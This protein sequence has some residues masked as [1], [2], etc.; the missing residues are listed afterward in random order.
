M[1]EIDKIKTAI[2]ALSSSEIARLR[3]WLATLDAQEF[4]A[5]LERD[6]RTGM[7]DHL[8]RKALADDK[9]KKT[10]DL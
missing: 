8:A 4:D 7:L 3:R 2:K 6:A 10:R 9:A 1:S 5:K